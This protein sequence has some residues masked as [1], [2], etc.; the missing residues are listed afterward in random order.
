[1]MVCVI[2]TNIFNNKRLFQYLGE[3]GELFT[4]KCFIA[5]FNIAMHLEMIIMNFKR[6]GSFFN[7]SFTLVLV[8]INHYLFDYL[9][10]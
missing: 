6:S 2:Y 7:D 4:K 8:L 10:L 3:S 9:L 5:T 1:M